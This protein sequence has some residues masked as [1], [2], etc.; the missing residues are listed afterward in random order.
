MVPGR[1]WEDRMLVVQ[2]GRRFSR[3]GVDNTGALKCQQLL[4]YFSSHFHLK[5]E[6]CPLSDSNNESIILRTTP[7]TPSG[8]Q[9]Y[10]LPATRFPSCYCKLLQ[11][12]AIHFEPL[13]VNTMATRL[14][15]HA[16]AN[17]SVTLHEVPI[18]KI[19][20]LGQILI[21]VNS[22]SCNPKDWKMATGN[23][24]TIRACPNSGDDMAGTVVEVGSSV[25]DF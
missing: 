21:K 18:P 23:L 8:A 25:V 24:M 4:S 14:E 12:V 11:L 16:K 5:V 9:K 17:T 15:A 6:L 13:Q 7:S 20:H 10:P 1:R 3:Q 2:E 19:T 22:A